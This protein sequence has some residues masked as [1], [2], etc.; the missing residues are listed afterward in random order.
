MSRGYTPNLRL[1]AWRSKKNLTQ[2][3]AGELAGISTNYYGKLESGQPIPNYVYERLHENGYNAG[4]DFGEN[5][6]EKSPVFGPMSPVHVVTPAYFRNPNGVD[7]V[8]EKTVAIPTTLA[9]L[10][11]KA[12]IVPDED[13]SMMP[14]Y[15]PGDALVFQLDPTRRA[16]FKYLIIDGDSILIRKLVWQHDC[17]MLVASNPDKERHPDQP[18]GSRKLGALILGFYRNEVGLETVQASKDGMR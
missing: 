11:S 1:K 4:A 12:Y 17:W 13:D 3:Q 18:L 15:R 7:S 6:L 5:D 8:L 10:G 16:G 2:K 9:K 14:E